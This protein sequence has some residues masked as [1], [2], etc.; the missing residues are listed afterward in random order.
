MTAQ[1]GASPAAGAATP[2]AATLDPSALIGA[3][4]SGGANPLSLILSQLGGQTPDNPAMALLS[5][6]LEQRQASGP[7]TGES[8]EEGN[9]EA[10]AA[11]AAAKRQER[12]RRMQELRE[13]VERVYAELEAL[14]A[15]N[16]ALAAALGACFLC[17]GTDPLC[18]ECGGRGV[19]GSRP[20]EPAAYRD[21]VVPALQRVRMMQAAPGR[22]PLRAAP[23][24]AAA[25]GGSRR[26]TRS[27]HPA[28]TAPPG[29][30]P[31]TAEAE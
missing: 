3:I 8:N 19:P 17:F 6:L 14:R 30:T 20:P 13:T 15:R 5:R 10:A 12:E 23:P 11:L 22:R 24:P 25:T 4:T 26:A 31:A 21:F 16:D 18:Q 29:V 2:D 28:A 27:W 1:D 7:E 9:A